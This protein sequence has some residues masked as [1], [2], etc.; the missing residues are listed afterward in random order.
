LSLQIELRFNHMVNS[1]PIQLDRVFHA[2]SDSTRRA[3]LV[4]ISKQEKTVGQIAGPFKMSLAAV[5]KHLTVLENANLI[6]RR[7]EGSFQ[8][9]SLKAEALMPVD[10]WIARYRQFWMP[11]LDSLKDFLEKEK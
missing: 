3:I 9:V 7:K 2:L 11:R 5:S 1:S 4:D 6:A 8:F 10:K